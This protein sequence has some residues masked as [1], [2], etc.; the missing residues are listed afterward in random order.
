MALITGTINTLERAL[1]YA[2]TKQKV[3]ADNI[4]NGDTPNYKVKSVSFGEML[5]SELKTAFTASKSD[6]RHFDLSIKSNTALGVYVNRNVSYNH[7]GNSVDIDKEMSDLATN[8]IYY[9]AVTDRI[10]GK[11]QSLENVIKGGR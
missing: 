2:S 10:I 3:V 8:T 11:F 1:N 6:S 5:D 7:N 9:N 4:A